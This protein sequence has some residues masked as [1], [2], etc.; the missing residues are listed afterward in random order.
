M[1]AMLLGSNGPQQQQWVA[2]KP[3]ALHGPPNNTAQPSDSSHQPHPT[4]FVSNMPCSEV[5]IATGHWPIISDCFP[6]QN[7]L[8]PH[9][10][11]KQIQSRGEKNMNLCLCLARAAIAGSNWVR[12]ERRAWSPLFVHAPRIPG[13]L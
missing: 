9:I 1:K 4:V 7:S 10:L 6:E 2:N 5:E 13:I 11:S 12:V 3:V 8:W